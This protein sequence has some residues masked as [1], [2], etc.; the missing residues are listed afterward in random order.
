MHR[1]CIKIFENKH[2]TTILHID[3]ENA[4]IILPYIFN[5]DNVLNEFR[6]IKTI[7]A[8]NDRNREK[9]CKVNA[10][11]TGKV[12]EMRFTKNNR[13]DRI[14]CIEKSK[15]QKRNIILIEL[16]KGKKSNDIPKKIITKLKIT[17][18]KYDYDV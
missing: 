8:E 18:S 7:L 13:N 10:V 12:F 14:Y 3:K 16:F 5:D 2:K 9:Y 1:N 11:N 6:I 4:Y 15:S 17:I